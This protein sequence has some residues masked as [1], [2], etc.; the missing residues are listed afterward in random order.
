MH[1]G[2]AAIQTL[3][4]FFAYLFKKGLKSP[5]VLKTYPYIYDRGTQPNVFD[6]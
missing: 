3:Q 4:H 2:N 1:I 6:F 5:K